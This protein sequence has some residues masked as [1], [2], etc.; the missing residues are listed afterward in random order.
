MGA[1]GLSANV[2]R[3]VNRPKSHP[4]W[5]QLMN[6][7]RCKRPDKVVFRNYCQFKAASGPNLGERRRSWLVR[8]ITC[9]RLHVVA[10]VIVEAYEGVSG[11]VDE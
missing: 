2:H 9:E 6:N 5:T 11:N 3:C 8:G 7:F 1:C 4:F 10:G